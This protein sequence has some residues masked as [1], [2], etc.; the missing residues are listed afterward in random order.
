MSPCPDRD[1]Y[2]EKLLW[3]EAPPEEMAAFESHAGGCMPCGEALAGATTF[4]AAMKAMIPAMASHGTN[5]RA[6]VLQQVR[7]GK[8]MTSK[9]TSWK[10]IRWRAMR[11]VILFGFLASLAIS[12]QG[13]MT[14]AIA[15]KRMRRDIAAAELK[16]I[17]H[18]IEQY[19]EKEGRL[20]ES[21]NAEM[22]YG[23]L[24]H[25]EPDR[26]PLDR[27]RLIEDEALDPWR[28]PYVFQSTDGSFVLYSMG[29]N[30]RRSG[31]PKAGT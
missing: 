8:L 6:A 17:S 14:V 27:D 12:F 1:A 7:V 26:L 15:R 21:G 28:R 3:G 31:S 23:L 4:D 25:W 5:P 24:L 22:V 20:P 2:I 10:T 16:G 29:E 9:A 11:W 30:G 19:R 13:Y 18:F